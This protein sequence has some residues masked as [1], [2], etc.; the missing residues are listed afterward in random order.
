[1]GLAVVA[2]A[3]TGGEPPP[4]RTVHQRYPHRLSPCAKQPTSGCHIDASCGFLTVRQCL[5]GTP[6]TSGTQKLYGVLLG[7]IGTGAAGGA[8]VLPTLKAKIGAD[9]T[10]EVGTAGTA[11][12][13]L[14]FALAHEPIMALMASVIAGIS[15]IAVVAALNVS[16]QV[17]LPDWVRGRGLAMYLSVFFGAMTLGSAIWG[18]VAAATGL[19]MAHFIAAAGALLAIPLTRRWKLQAAVGIDLTPSVRWPTPVITRAIEDHRGPVLVTMEYR[20]IPTERD[21]FLAAIDRLERARRRD[22]AYAWGVFEDTAEQGRFLE[23]FLIEL[24]LE[25]LRQHERVTN[26]DRVLEQHVRRLVRDLPK[27]THLIAAE[28][29]RDTSKQATE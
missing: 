17:A 14:L 29:R 20:I 28:P 1:M 21:A 9:R 19:P 16:A 12:A 25:H 26:A 4:C 2:P 13:L 22:G 18:K 10:A 8:F 3:Q 15:W 27:V 23:T 24:W 11:V 7:A 5:L 6:S